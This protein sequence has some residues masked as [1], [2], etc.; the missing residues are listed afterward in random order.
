[1]TGIGWRF[2]RRLR[3]A[4][5]A[6]ATLVTG[7][8][9]A[10]PMY[11]HVHGAT[12]RLEVPGGACSGTAISRTWV[13]TA[14]HCFEADKPATIKANGK[15]CEVR[16]IV[17]DGRDHALVRLRGCTFSVTAKVGRAPRVGDAIF[18]WGNPYTFRDMLRFGRVA[19]YQDDAMPGLGRAMMVDFNGWPGDSGAALFNWR[20]EIC[21]VVSIGSQPYRL[22][23]VFPFAFTRKQWREATA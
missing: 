9:D 16:T 15:T 7:C 1:M 20:G 18:V 22:M 12:L 21:A 2:D 23:G 4:V 5:A 13:L 8:A 17:H 3:V 14:S 6:L 10:R 11:D 19:G